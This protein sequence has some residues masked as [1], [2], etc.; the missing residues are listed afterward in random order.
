MPSYPC[1]ICGDPRAFL[2]WPISEPEPDRCP[3]D[4]ERDDG[5]RT[6]NVTECASQMMMARQAVE[7]LKNA[8]QCFDRNGVMLPGRLAEALGFAPP[9]ENG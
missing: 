4:Y 2:F 8:P 1:P 6:R 9:R 7:L 3:D 5:A